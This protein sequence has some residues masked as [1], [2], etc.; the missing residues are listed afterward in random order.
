MILEEAVEEI[1]SVRESD[2]NYVISINNQ[3]EID[4]FYRNW[5]ESTED[6][7][8]DER[9]K[10]EEDAVQFAADKLMSC[11][12]I[13]NIKSYVSKEILTKMLRPFFD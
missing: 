7:L 12:E 8:T 3:K 4:V 9:F 6:C 13:L 1:R 2:R 11:I 10:T 5:Y